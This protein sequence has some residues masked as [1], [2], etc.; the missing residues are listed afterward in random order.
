MRTISI[1]IFEEIQE[2]LN[3]VQAEV[4]K[5]ASSHPILSHKAEIFKEPILATLLLFS[6][7]F[8]HYKIEKLFPTAVAVELL[9]LAV[10]EHYPIKSFNKEGEKEEKEDE[11]ETKEKDQDFSSNL[12]LIT[13]DFYY[14]R[15]IMLVAAL[16]DVLVIRILA[17]SIASIAEAM[18]TTLPSE[19]KTKDL[20]QGYVEWVKKMVSLYDAASYLGG[21]LSSV[22]EEVISSLRSFGQG[23]GGLLYSSQYLK[24]EVIDPKIKEGI[25]SWFKKEVKEALNKFVALGLEI[26][27]IPLLS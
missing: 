19:G 11:R 26:E 22:S 6:G 18:S 15:A 16:K 20:I 1:P 7:K 3:K 10:E 13:G 8:G 24:G 27:E 9:E 21:Y 17:E 12:S 25:D 14:S 4:K 5:E 23:L 2:D